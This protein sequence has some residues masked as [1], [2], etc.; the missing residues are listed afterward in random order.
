MMADGP[1][2][3]FDDLIVFEVEHLVSAQTGKPL[4]KVRVITDRAIALGQIDPRDAR[5]IAGHLLECAARAEYEADFYTAAT[6]GG[7]D[8]QTVG[9]VMHLLR[10]G[11]RTRHEKD[12]TG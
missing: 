8:E 6:T 5:Q 2:P 3:V 12:D 1:L 10:F 9:M 4:V 11:E 7:L